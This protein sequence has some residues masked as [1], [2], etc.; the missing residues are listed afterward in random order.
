MR[1]SVCSVRVAEVQPHEVAIQTVRGG[2]RG[3]HLARDLLNPE[4]RFSAAGV[5]RAALRAV[6]PSG[7]G[8]T[9]H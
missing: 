7:R 6:L 9:S 8:P 1:W 5:E 3:P 2:L 4:P